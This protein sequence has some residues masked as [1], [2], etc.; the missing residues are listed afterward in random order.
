MRTVTVV[1]SIAAVPERVWHALVSPAEVARWDGSEPLAVPGTYPEPGQ[2]ARWSA[3]LGGVAL[4]LHDQVRR[5]EPLHLLAASIDLGP[6]HLEEEYRLEATAGGTLLVLVD[7]VTTSLP[8]LG[9]A[10]AWWTRRSTSAALE[11]LRRRCERTDPGC[12]P[13]GSGPER[14]PAVAPDRPGTW[15]SGAPPGSGAAW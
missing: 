7:V 13:A 12:A 10:A 15:Q 9:P 4:V 8:G 11:R 6:L 3:R 5:V 1:V 14:A 2:Y